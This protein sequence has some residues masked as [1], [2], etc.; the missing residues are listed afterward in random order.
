MKQKEI[1]FVTFKMQ[2]QIRESFIPFYK[3][4]SSQCMID[5]ENTFIEGSHWKYL[6]KLFAKKITTDFIAASGRL[7]P[8]MPID[9]MHTRLELQK[10]KMQNLF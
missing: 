5:M 8:A 1:D 7:P 2:H 6:L 4:K 10:I 9:V 3:S